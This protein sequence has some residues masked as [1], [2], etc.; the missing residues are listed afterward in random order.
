MP[1]SSAPI[2]RNKTIQE[3]INNALLWIG[4]AQKHSDKEDLFSSTQVIANLS[5]AIDSLSSAIWWKVREMQQQDMD[6]RDG[7]L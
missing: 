3:N 2:D 6:K 4:H 1:R 7:Y 5:T